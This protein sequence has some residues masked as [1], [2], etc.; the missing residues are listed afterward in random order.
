[1]KI[2]IATK[3][4]G[5]FKEI[6]E[7]V[8]SLPHEF[9]GLWDLGIEEDFFEGE[10]T[11]EGNAMGKARFYNQLSGLP[12]IAD[13]SG[14]FVEALAGELGVKTR[15]WGAGEKASDEDWIKFFIS[16]IAD[17]KN[18]KAKFVC[19]AA[20]YKGQNG[21]AIFRGETNGILTAELMAPITPG[22]PISSMFIPEGS[23]K[24][25]SLLKIEEKNKISHR[26]KA[27]K[28]LFDHLKNV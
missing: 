14:I 5:K 19:V 24:V 17:E 7:V 28:Q 25:Y 1:M 20:F 21:E 12:T 23:D 26:G 13:D 10:D 4:R 18:R 15:R 11:F 9:V 3:N 16:R 27:F 22:I 8:D 6:K 2:L